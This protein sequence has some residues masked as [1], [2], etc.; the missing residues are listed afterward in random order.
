MTERWVEAWGAG[1]W[2]LCVQHP[3]VRM[4][5][6]EVSNSLREVLPHSQGCYVLLTVPTQRAYVGTSGDLASRVPGSIGRN[7]PGATHVLTVEP[8]GV[9]WSESQRL[10]LEG[11]LIA[12][13]VGVANRAAGRTTTTTS[14]YLDAVVEEAQATASLLLPRARSR[15]ADRTLS[16]GR[17]AQQLVLGELRHPLTV[18]ELSERLRDLGWTARGRTVHRTLR[19]DLCDASRGGSDTVRVTGPW[20]DPGSLVFVVGR[21][22]SSGWCPPAATS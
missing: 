5:V 20:T 4:T 10:E 3:A 7:Q 9:P 1:R 19:R 8:L 17:I 22:Y 18:G 13:L 11:R 6:L 15:H 2:V 14:P 16:Q 12:A 21:R